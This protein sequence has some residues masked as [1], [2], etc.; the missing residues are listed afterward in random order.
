LTANSRISIHCEQQTTKNDHPMFAGR[1]NFHV[2]LDSDR[3]PS[4]RSP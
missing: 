2:V 4:A 1:H 3:G